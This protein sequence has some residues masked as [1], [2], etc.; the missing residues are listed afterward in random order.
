MLYKACSIVLW[1]L[2]N[3]QGV[4]LEGSLPG[5]EQGEE[6]VGCEGPGGEGGYL[7]TAN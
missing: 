3:P 4:E 2:T 1:S 7:S 6:L 5:S